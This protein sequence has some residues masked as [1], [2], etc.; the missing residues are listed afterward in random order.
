M[1]QVSRWPKGLSCMP[2]CQIDTLSA[3]HVSAGPTEI[4]C[5]GTSEMFPPPEVRAFCAIVSGCKSTTRVVSLRYSAGEGGLFLYCFSRLGGSLKAQ[6][7]T[8]PCPPCITAQRTP[9]S[10]LLR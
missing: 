5:V 4:A 10:Q 9:L 8:S 2:A 6:C 7:F 3:F 1:K